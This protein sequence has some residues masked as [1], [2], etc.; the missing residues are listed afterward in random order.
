ME[1]IQCNEKTIDNA[2]KESTRS[3]VKVMF[4]SEKIYAG[5]ENHEGSREAVGG[6]DNLL[7]RDLDLARVDLVN[8]VVWGLAVDGAA[9][10]LSGTQDL[11]AA[12]SEVLGEGF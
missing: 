2:N 11:L 6:G 12:V 5:D 8:D 7:L 4:M 9:D 1:N 3:H 10:G